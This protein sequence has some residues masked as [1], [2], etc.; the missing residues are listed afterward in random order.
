MN[1][2]KEL[3]PALR[4]ELYAALDALHEQCEEVE[5]APEQVRLI[6]RRLCSLARQLERQRTVRPDC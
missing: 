4:T 3:D 1:T 5:P 2:T 6:G